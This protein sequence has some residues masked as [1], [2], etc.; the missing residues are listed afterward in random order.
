MLDQTHVTILSIFHCISWEVEGVIGYRMS[1]REDSLVQ[2]V[3]DKVRGW[4][5]G[6]NIWSA[7]VY[8]PLALNFQTKLVVG[9]QNFVD[10][11]LPNM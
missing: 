5:K 2:T 4:K 3:P 6:E 9:G 11:I 10:L 1:K 7:Y 8:G